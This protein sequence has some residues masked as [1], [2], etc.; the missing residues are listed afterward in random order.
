MNE[1]ATLSFSFEAN[2]KITAVLYD[3]QGKLLRTL[4]TELSL[5]SGKHQHSF[6]V[7]D[8]S[9]GNYFIRVTNELH[10]NIVLDF[11]RE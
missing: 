9:P 10:Q 11:I 5:P 8:L 4:F 7:N 1:V 3:C 2:Q 6:N